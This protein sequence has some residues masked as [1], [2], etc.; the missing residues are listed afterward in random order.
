LIKSSTP[1]FTT[2][3][4]KGGTG[5]GLSLCHGIVAEHAGKIYAK[6]KPGKGTTFFVELPLIAEK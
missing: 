2:R 5:L 1:F 6:S 4:E 3:G